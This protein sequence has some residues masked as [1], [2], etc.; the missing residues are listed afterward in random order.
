MENGHKQL[1][2]AAAVAHIAQLALFFALGAA[3]LGV[4]APQ[5]LGQARVANASFG[6]LYAL[7]ATKL[8]MAHMSKEPYEVTAWP[9]VLL[10]VQPAWGL[11]WRVAMSG[12]GGLSSLKRLV[13]TFNSI[14]DYQ[15]G[16]EWQEAIDALE[17]VTSQVSGDPR[18]FDLTGD[19]ERWEQAGGDEISEANEFPTVLYEKWVEVL[20]AAAEAL[21]WEPAQ[22][23]G[24]WRNLQKWGRALQRVNL[25]FGSDTGMAELQDIIET[26]A[27]GA[28][29]QRKRKAPVEEAPAEAPAAEEEGEEEEEPE[30]KKAKGD[31]D[32]DDDEDA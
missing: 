21:E 1:G 2:K 27:S 20:T 11:G 7:Q 12:R 24:L 14:E 22:W 31:D 17:S 15:E 19:G 32:D 3:M 5:Q 25:D 29:K 13:K 8:I 23:E 16:E 6:I 4:G 10:A 9:L 18:G 28:P 30:A 26:Y